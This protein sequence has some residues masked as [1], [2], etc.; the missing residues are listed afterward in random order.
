MKTILGKKIGMT[1]IFTDGGSAIP[2]T[3][4]NAGPCTVIRKRDKG[5][6]VGFREIRKEAVTRL[7]NK[8]LRLS[9]EKAGVKPFR[10]VRTL[11]EVGNQVAASLPNALHQAIADGLQ[12]TAEEC[13][14]HCPTGALAF[15]RPL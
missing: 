6:E 1:Q 5:V 14:H 4:I 3:V 9:F 10:F 15:H 13:V 7:L 11:P 2:V 8:P 12:S